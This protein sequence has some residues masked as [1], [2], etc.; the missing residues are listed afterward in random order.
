[1]S[2]ERCEKG[3]YRS[4]LA[5]GEPVSA[6][7]RRPHDV[8]YRRDTLFPESDPSSG[9]KGGPRT[10]AETAIRRSRKRRPGRPGPGPRGHY[11]TRRPRATPKLHLVHRGLDLPCYFSILARRRIVTSGSRFSDL[12][13][14]SLQTRA[15]K[16]STAMGGAGA[17]CSV[18]TGLT[19]FP[20]APAAIA[21]YPVSRSLKAAMMTI[22]MGQLSMLRRASLPPR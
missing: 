18:V 20:E 6:A 19:R 7:H 2:G 9:S 4:G 22:V 5:P 16:R 11:Q 13:E 12:R 3:G 1:M 21:T 10:A 14:R 15:A 8:P 17:V